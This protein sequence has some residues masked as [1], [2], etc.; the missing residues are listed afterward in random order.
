MGPASRFSCSAR[1]SSRKGEM[2]GA[3]PSASRGRAMRRDADTHGILCS[4]EQ[5]AG[6]QRATFNW[7]F[8]IQF[9]CAI[10]VR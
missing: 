2:T 9:A 5:R 10:T 4:R 7:P 1:S 6:V 8:G 3:L